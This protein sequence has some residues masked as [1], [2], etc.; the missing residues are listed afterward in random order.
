MTRLCIYPL[1]TLRGVVS[2]RHISHTN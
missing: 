1:H 2:C